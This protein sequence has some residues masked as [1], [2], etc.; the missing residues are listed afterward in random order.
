MHLF[1]P[2]FKAGWKYALISSVGV[3][4]A[5]SVI[6]QY[7]FFIYSYQFQAFDLYLADE[8]RRYIQVE[9]ETVTIGPHYDHYNSFLRIAELGVEFANATDRIPQIDLFFRRSTFTQ[10][11]DPLYNETVLPNMPL[12]GTHGKLWTYMEQNIALGTAP[13]GDT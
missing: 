6:T 11:F 2:L 9:V 7:V 13:E 4:L 1:K 5:V 8:D 12:Y 10:T 3:T